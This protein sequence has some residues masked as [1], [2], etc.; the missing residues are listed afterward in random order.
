MAK[1]T[2]KET[3]FEASGKY[4][5]KKAVSVETTDPMLGLITCKF[6]AGVVTPKSEQEEAA[7]KIAVASGVAEV[8]EGA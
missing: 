3:S 5:V 6:A 2:T 4:H 7:L 8:D 1:K